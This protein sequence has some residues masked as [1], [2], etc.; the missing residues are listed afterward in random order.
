MEGLQLPTSV[1]VAGYDKSNQI[2]R[3]PFRAY[4]SQLERFALEADAFLF[5]GYG[6]ADLHLN[7]CF[8]RIR[9]AAKR[10]VVIIDYADKSQ[11]PL[12]FRRDEWS[13]NLHSA[14]PFDASKMSYRGHAAA[15]AIGSIKR[16]KGFETSDDPDHPLAVWYGG[17][18]K[19]CEQ[20][21]KIHCLLSK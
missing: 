17:F 7:K 11:N 21:D 1:I 2:K 18:L 10:P 12:R 13:H 4:F 14:I 19:A 15:V 9:N 8:D 3:N 16:L 6:F 5:L 20:Y